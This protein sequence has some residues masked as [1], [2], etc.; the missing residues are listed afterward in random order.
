MARGLL[1]EH[2]EH[3]GVPVPDPDAVVPFHLV[4]DVEAVAGGAEVGAGAAGEALLMER[5]PEGVLEVGI[6]DRLD[7]VG[8]DAGGDLC[9]GLGRDPLFRLL[10]LGA[11]GR[12][13]EGRKELLAFGR[14]ELGQ[15]LI[16]QV[17]QEDVRACGVGRVSADGGAEAGRVGRVDASDRHDGGLGP[18][19]DV[20]GVFV[21]LLVEQHVQEG[22]APGIA[23]ADSEEQG[24]CPLL[25]PAG[26]NHPLRGPGVLQERLGPGKEKILRRVSRVRKIGQGFLARLQD[27]E[28]D[29]VLR[30]HRGDDPHLPRQIP[31][32]AGQRLLLDEPFFHTVPYRSLTSYRRKP[33]SSPFRTFWTPASAGV[34]TYTFSSPPG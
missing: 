8:R 12:S 24:L 6:Q 30:L 25:R 32:D 19:V 20:V 10:G 13:P 9:G 18:L 27:A 23:G 14:E 15:V 31:D 26:G 3:A 28:E 17:G 22:E 29:L 34:T 11:R 7:L 2:W 5:V 33:V 16:P 4:A 21:L 1:R